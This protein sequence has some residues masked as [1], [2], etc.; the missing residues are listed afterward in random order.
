MNSREKRVHHQIH[1]LK[2]AT[3]IGVT[4]ISLYFLWQHRMAPAIVVGFVPP[5][6]V[7]TWMMIWP[8]D[9][10]GMKNSALGNYISEYMIPIVEVVRFLSL[11]PMAWG[12]W[13]RHVWLIALGL[14]VLWL[15]WCDGLI[16]PRCR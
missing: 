4:P 16:F 6:I 13:S 8:P 5:I 10:G 15:A 11:V 2:L 12:A 14:L 7:S 3:D 1:P 9:L